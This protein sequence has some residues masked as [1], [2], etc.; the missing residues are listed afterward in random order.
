MAKRKSISKKTRF[1]VFKRDS[2]TCQYCGRSAPDIVLHL[3]HIQ[4]VSKGG[5]NDILNLVTSCVDCNAGKSDRLLSDDSAVLKQKAQLDALNERREQLE[6][7]IQ[8]RSG[9]RQLGHTELEALNDAWSEITGY[10]LT[11]SEKIAARKHIKKFGL[12]A[13]LVAVDKSSAYLVADG[14]GYTSE[15]MDLAWSKVGGIC[16]MDSLPQWQQRI[17]HIRNIARKRADDT[18]YPQSCAEIYQL[19]EEAYHMGFSFDQLEEVARRGLGYKTLADLLARS[20]SA[21]KADNMRRE[22]QERERLADEALSAR[23]N[24]LIDAVLSTPPDAV[25]WASAVDFLQETEEMA[26]PN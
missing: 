7:M 11:E 3:E 8:W 6:M 22:D 21:A 24:R 12:N 26:Y 10:Y 20:I 4:P 25:T 14:D 23:E 19:L 1:E 2:F 18:W 9:L 15:S 13:C 17:Y 16:R 5:D